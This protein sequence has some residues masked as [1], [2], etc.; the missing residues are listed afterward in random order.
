[1]AE[2]NK[3]E[4][5]EEVIEEVEEKETQEVIE[6]V[7]EKETE[8]EKTEQKGEKKLLFII[9]AVVLAV[10]VAVAAA[11]IVKNAA[12][13]NFSSNT[14]QT[15]EDGSPASH[16]AAELITGENAT[17]GA[18]VTDADA[19]EKIRSYSDEQLGIKK[20]DYSFLVAR[21]GYVIEGKNYIQV[22]AA[23]KKENEDGTFSITPF[24]KY[25]ISFDGKT[26]L[27]EDMENEGSY[28][29]LK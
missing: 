26:V 15:L 24:G 3:K 10:A 4:L 17:E 18:A 9:A 28:T 13:G 20:E 8:E 19:I 14:K 6:E 29:E 21:Q 16:D 7:E 12:D 22:I 1:M 5:T 11:V 25:Y 23:E 2:E 27:K